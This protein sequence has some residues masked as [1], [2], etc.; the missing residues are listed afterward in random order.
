MAAQNVIGRDVQI[1]YGSHADIKRLLKIMHAELPSDVLYLWS[2]PT[3]AALL[4][5]LLLLIGS[6][7]TEQR[8][9]I[10]R[11]AIEALQSWTTGHGQKEVPVLAV[12]AQ[13]AGE[14][15]EKPESV[16]RPLPGKSWIQTVPE[17]GDHGGEGRDKDH[18]AVRKGARPP[19]RK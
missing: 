3:E 4:N 15:G 12:Q 17:L 19:R 7:Q 13:T 8:Q 9:A 2:V 6:Q 14:G 10:C 18:G 5:G 11:A 16:Y 1:S